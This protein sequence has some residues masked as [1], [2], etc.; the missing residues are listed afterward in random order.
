MLTGLVEP[1]LRVGGSWALAGLEV[2]TPDSV[3]LPV[4]PP[5]G[6][7]VTVDVFPVVAPGIRVTGVQAMENPGVATAVTVTDVVAVATP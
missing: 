1:K 5:A 3:T 2:T 7:T 4:R 6:V